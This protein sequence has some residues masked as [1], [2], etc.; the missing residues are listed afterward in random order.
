[1][2]EQY[3]RRATGAWNIAA[4]PARVLNASTCMH[5]TV[6]ATGLLTIRHSHVTTI[7]LH[8]AF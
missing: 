1:M 8:E 3:S 5:C 6:R 4:P 7:S 2:K